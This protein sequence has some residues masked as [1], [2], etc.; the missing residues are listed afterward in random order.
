M[1]L[2]LFNMK[3]LL[4]RMKPLKESTSVIIITMAS[5]AIILERPTLP[6]LKV[7]KLLL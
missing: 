4:F 3:L 1:K 6:L 2:L 5:M 7:L